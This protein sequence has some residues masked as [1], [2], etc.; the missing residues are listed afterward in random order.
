MSW[1][2]MES[3]TKTGRVKKNSTL[4]DV[5]LG[6]QVLLKADFTCDN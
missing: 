5:K 6:M 1:S 3:F 4:A 2:S